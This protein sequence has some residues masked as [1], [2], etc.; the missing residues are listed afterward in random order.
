MILIKF[1]SF[2]DWSI[3]SKLVMIMIF[4]V[5]VVSEEKKTGHTNTRVWQDEEDYS[6]YCLQLLRQDTLSRLLYPGFLDKVV[7]YAY[8]G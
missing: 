8:S 2:S 5:L 7:L 4:R 3:L 6:P 1:R